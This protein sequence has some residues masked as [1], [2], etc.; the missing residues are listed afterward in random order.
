MILINKLPSP[1]SLVSRNLSAGLPLVASPEGNP[2]VSYQVA[3][4][5]LD[6]FEALVLVLVLF[7]VMLAVFVVLSITTRGKPLFWQPAP[8]TWAR[9]S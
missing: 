6:V 5:L 8:G 9:R 3:K 7:P 4:R 2:S 1:V